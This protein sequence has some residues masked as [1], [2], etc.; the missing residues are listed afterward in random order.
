V[1]IDLPIVRASLE[2]GAVTDGV[3]RLLADVERLGDLDPG[4]MALVSEIRA[5]GDG[6]DA[7]V[8]RHP[9]AEVILPLG[10]APE[11]LAELRAV[12]ADVAI[13]GT[14]GGGDHEPRGKPT[15]DLRF[16][17]QVVVSFPPSPERF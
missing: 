8:L 12:L 17:A 2:D 3:R 6:G 9:E 5:A 7:M 13:R 11:R 1:R 4:M 14:Q 10:A 16:E 15:I